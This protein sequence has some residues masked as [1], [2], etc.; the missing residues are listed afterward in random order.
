MTSP[1]DIVA[2]PG[3]RNK[4]ARRVV[5][6]AWI[7]AGKPPINSAGRTYEQQKHMYN[8]WRQGKGNAADNPDANTRQPHVRG[9]ALDLA[10]WTPKIIAAMESAGF[11]RP[12][13]VRN[14]F[15]QDEPWHFELKKFVGTIKTIGKVTSTAANGAKPFVP[16]P[17][18]ITKELIDMATEVLVTQDIDKKTGKDRIKDEDRRAA[19]VN[20]DSGYKVT[21]SWLAVSDAEAWAKSAGMPNGP[22]KFTDS[23]FNAFLS[24]LPGLK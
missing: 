5:V 24:G 20:T 18:P 6:E 14:G 17:P 3:Y 9:M 8:L 22:Y 10:S 12:I 21:F 15:S 7:A 11:T 2:I 4:W 13:W 1:M 16:T 19:F 23:G